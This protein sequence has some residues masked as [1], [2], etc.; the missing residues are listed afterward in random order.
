MFLCVL[1][2][3]SEADDQGRAGLLVPWTPRTEQPQ[4]QHARKQRLDACVRTYLY[5]LYSSA[6]PCLWK[7]VGFGAEENDEQAGGD[8]CRQEDLSGSTYGEVS[9]LT[10]LHPS[11]KMAG[12]EAIMDIHAFTKGLP[13]FPYHKILGWTQT[14]R[15]TDD[16][17]S[18]LAEPRWGTLPH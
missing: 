5:F 4:T 11:P 10:F 2:R 13:L 3:G 9:K 1:D 6:H 18:P 8:E 17:A 15:Q 7:V 16:R 14:A 12:A